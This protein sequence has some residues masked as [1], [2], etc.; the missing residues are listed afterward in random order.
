[1][2]ILRDHLAAAA[3]AVV[4]LAVVD[5][6]CLNRQMRPDRAR[7]PVF[8]LWGGNADSRSRVLPTSRERRPPL[9]V[10]LAPILFPRAS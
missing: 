8:N 4:D 2:F 3:D 5:R 9:D 1:L 6:A 7:N 10:W